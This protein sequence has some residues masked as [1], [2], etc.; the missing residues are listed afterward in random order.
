MHAA[1]SRGGSCAGGRP[2]L[3]READLQAAAPNV[4]RPTTAAAVHKTHQRASTQ[5]RPLPSTHRTCGLYDSE[6]RETIL[7]HCSGVAASTKPR[8]M[9]AA[10]RTSLDTSAD[11][12]AEDKRCQARRRDAGAHVCVATGLER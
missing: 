12:M 8:F 5:S 6:S 3:K 11:K 1:C 10:R 4:P 2:S 9:T 7:G